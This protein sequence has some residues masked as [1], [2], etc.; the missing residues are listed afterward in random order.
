VTPKKA[1]GRRRASQAKW[2]AD[3]LPEGRDVLDGL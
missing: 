1:E 2:G 3:L